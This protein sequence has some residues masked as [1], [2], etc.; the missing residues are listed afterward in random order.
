MYIEI[1]CKL[2]ESRDYEQRLASEERT[3]HIRLTR[4]RELTDEFESAPPPLQEG[5]EET[6]VSRLRNKLLRISNDLEMS[7]ERIVKLEFEEKNC[8][9]EI[10]ELNGEQER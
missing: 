5:T 8:R 10:E 7:R 4:Q 9:E 6:Q 3:L 2:N 1:Y